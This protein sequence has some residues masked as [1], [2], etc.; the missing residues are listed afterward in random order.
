MHE[1][2]FSEQYKSFAA[3]GGARAPQMADEIEMTQRLKSLVQTNQKNKTNLHRNFQRPP[4]FAEELAAMH[5]SAEPEGVFKMQSPAFK[6]GT[7][8][9]NNTS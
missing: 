8:G 1:T 2:S 5:R 7:H 9:A 4:V 6:P 3:V